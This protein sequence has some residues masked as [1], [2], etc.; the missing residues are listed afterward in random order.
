VAGYND[1]LIHVVCRTASPLC[2]SGTPS[3]SNPI[4]TAVG[5][6]ELVAGC[7]ATTTGLGTAGTG[8]DNTPAFSTAANTVAAFQNSGTCG[9][10][11]GEL[12]HGARRN[13]G[14][15]WQCLLRGNCARPLA[16]GVGPADV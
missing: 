8:L 6:M 7:A 4:L 15:I 13:R 3:A 14:R 10:S 5:N 2:G 16:C 1:D 12:K 11:K 9:T